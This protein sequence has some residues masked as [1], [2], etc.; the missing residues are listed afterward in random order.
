MTGCCIRYSVSHMQKNQ[1][2]SSQGNLKM[3][4]LFQ[5]SKHSLCFRMFFLF[6]SGSLN[7]CVQQCF[8]FCA[9]DGSWY[10]EEWDNV[11]STIAWD[12]ARQ[13]LG[14]WIFVMAWAMKNMITLEK[15]EPCCYA[16]RILWCS[17][18]ISLFHVT[19]ITCSLFLYKLHKFSNL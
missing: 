1:T 5:K 7:L 17:S 10:A 6:L 16:E 15:T 14:R 4:L 3:L 19:S 2:W 12:V 13:V 9:C 8:W 18:S 11:S